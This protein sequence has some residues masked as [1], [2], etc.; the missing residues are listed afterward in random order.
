MPA[1]IQRS[2]ACP[3]FH[4]RVVKPRISTLTAQ[5]VVGPLTWDK[6]G[7][8]TDPKYVFYIWKNGT[9]AEL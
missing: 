1:A 4:A 9:Y 5:T 7:D 2:R 3:P 8:V 6:K